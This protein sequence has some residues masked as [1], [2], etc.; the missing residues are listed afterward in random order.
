MQSPLKGSFD[1]QQLQQLLHGTACASAITP[2]ETVTLSVQKA[3]LYKVALRNRKAVGLGMFFAKAPP[4]DTVMAD[5][6]EL[7]DRVNW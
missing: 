3:R 6:R 4:F 2:T 7:E 1:P 5:L